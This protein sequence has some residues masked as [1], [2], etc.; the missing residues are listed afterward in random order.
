MT[1]FGSTDTVEAA[2]LLWTSFAERLK[3]RGIKCRVFDVNWFERRY[4]SL[5]A[6]Y[7]AWDTMREREGA[8][9]YKLV[10]YYVNAFCGTLDDAWDS[11]IR[12]KMREREGSVRCQ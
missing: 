6:R 12:D 2:L 7:D 9:R 10:R 8:V 1:R 11:A 4:R 3:M 5:R